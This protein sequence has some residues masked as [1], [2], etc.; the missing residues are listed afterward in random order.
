[1]SKGEVG[2]RKFSQVLTPFR[3]SVS[4]NELERRPSLFLLHKATGIN[5][6][7]DP[8]GEWRNA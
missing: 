6:L 1:M 7:L 8:S 5:A 4:E 2:G 3:F